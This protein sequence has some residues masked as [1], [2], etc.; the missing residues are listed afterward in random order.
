M[1]WS[2]PHFLYEGMLCSMAAFTQHATFGFWKG[3]LV[4]TF[5]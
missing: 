4:P 2:F 1:K 5:A 3:S